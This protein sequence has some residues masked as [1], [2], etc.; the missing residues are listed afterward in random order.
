MISPEGA[1]SILWHDST[2]ARDAATG[3]KIYGAGFASAWCHRWYHRRTGRRRARDPETAIQRV[4]E[5]IELALLDFDGIE[6]A[7][8]RRQRQE[9]FLADW[10]IASRLQIV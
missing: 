6:G 1:A 5:A 2:K 8:I 3:M 7:D 4:G 10:K 9:N